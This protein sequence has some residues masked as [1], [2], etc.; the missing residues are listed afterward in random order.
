MKKKIYKKI[1]LK[2]DRNYVK[3]NIFKCFYKRCNKLLLFFV[4]KLF[5]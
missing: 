5:S 1:L 3:D 2:D 4:K